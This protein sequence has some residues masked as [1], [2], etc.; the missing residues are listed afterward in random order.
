MMLFSKMKG[1]SIFSSTLFL[2]QS[3]CK[4]NT[5]EYPYVEVVEYNANN[6]IEDRHCFTKL[7]S[8]NGFTASVFDGHGGALTVQVIQFRQNM[9]PKI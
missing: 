5:T 8:I 2:S 9:H 4:S 7:Q 6:P 1:L 3:F